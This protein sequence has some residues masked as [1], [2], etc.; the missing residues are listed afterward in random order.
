[1]VDTN[2]INMNEITIKTNTKYLKR[3]MIRNF[4]V[5]SIVNA[6]KIGNDQPLLFP[7]FSTKQIYK[8]NKSK[9]QKRKNAFEYE[10]E[11]INN[12]KKILKSLQIKRM[13][14]YTINFIHKN[15]SKSNEH[16]NK[17]YIPKQNKVKNEKLIKISTNLFS[18]RIQEVHIGIK[19][20]LASKHLP[21]GRREKYHQL[22]EAPDSWESNC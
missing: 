15:K 21:L 10:N 7:K 6:R 17:S 16:D 9:L 19:M 8:Y 2:K 3:R 14:K 12:A 4:E 20:N 18:K 22:G 5:M 13:N 1:M 11:R